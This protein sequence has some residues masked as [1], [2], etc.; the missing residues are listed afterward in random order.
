MTEFAGFAPSP[1]PA[2]PSAESARLVRRMSGNRRL[3][4]RSRPRGLS[5]RLNRLAIQVFGHAWRSPKGARDVR[6][7]DARGRFVSTSD[8]D[9]VRGVLLWVHGGGFVAGTPRMDQHIAAGYCG[10]IGIPAFVPRYRRAPE[11]TFPAAADDVLAAYRGLLEQGYAAPEI[12]VAGL[13]A[14]GALVAGLLGDLTRDGLPMPGAVLLVSPLLDLTTATL[15][16][17]DAVTRDPFISPDFVER[18]NLAYAGDTPLTHPRLDVLS[19][20]MRRWPPILVQT[21]GLECVSG[22]ARLLGSRM[23]A[24]GSPCEVQL[25]PGQIHGF[26][27]FKIPEGRAAFAY[28]VR[29]LADPPVTRPGAA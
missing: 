23:R 3:Q 10:P 5:L 19:A 7:G 27:F 13:S 14:G 17:T 25:W 11:H 6:F 9:R 26:P 4:A 24:A 15:R 1:V 16:R 12:R 22:D 28:G 29:F 18:A 20:D 2:E 8:S 21:G